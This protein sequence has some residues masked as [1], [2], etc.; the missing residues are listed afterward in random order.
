M[1][2][3]LGTVVNRLLSPP[4]PNPEKLTTYE[5]G[6]APIGD[7]VVQLNARFYLIGLIFLIFDVEVIFLYPWATVFA[8]RELIDEVSVWGQFALIEML[9]FVGVLLLGLIYAWA[10]GDL[11]WVKP[12]QKSSQVMAQVGS[13]RYAEVNERYASI[14]KKPSE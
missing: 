4:K 11:D 13:G 6:E 7:A 10:K 8:K 9:I 5:S 3:L 12:T 2:V 14:S 1:F